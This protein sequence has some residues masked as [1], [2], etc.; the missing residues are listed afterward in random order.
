MQ[1]YFFPLFYLL[2]AAVIK[3]IAVEQNLSLKKLS[4]SIS[5]DANLYYIRMSSILMID[6]IIMNLFENSLKKFESN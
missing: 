6:P 4:V 3:K 2:V 1:D 5:Q